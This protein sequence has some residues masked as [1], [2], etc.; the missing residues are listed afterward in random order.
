M[1]RLINT[2]KNNTISLIFT[3]VGI[4]LVFYALYRETNISYICLII[5]I[6]IAL[7]VFYDKVVE[8]L[9]KGPKLYIPVASLITIISIISIKMSSIEEY[10]KYSIWLFNGGSKIIRSLGFE[11]GTLLLVTLI[12]S[13]IFYYFTV[14]IIRIPVVLLL[15]YMVT[16]LFIKCVYRQENLLL[17]AFVLLFFCII[18][19]GNRESV[20]GEGRNKIKDKD[21]ISISWIFILIIFI[22]GVWI[23]KPNKLPKVKA[24]DYV[25]SY[26]LK[27]SSIGSNNGFSVESNKGRSINESTMKNPS[28]L[29][30]TF[31]G[32]NPKY[33][34]SHNYDY[35]ENENW[36]SGNEE[37]L[38]GINIK[39]YELN[40]L[41]DGT[42]LLVNK[43][44]LNNIKSLEEDNSL[45]KTL[46]LRINNYS[47][48]QIVH[49]INIMGANIEDSNENI[50][51]NE[52]GVLFLKDDGTFSIDDT[53]E[54]NYLSDRPSKGT[55]EE[56]IMRY[57]NKERY[58]GLLE[59]VGTIV[60]KKYGRAEINKI[61]SNY[62][63]TSELSDE[64]IELSKVIPEGN[65]SDYDIA[66]S[67]EDYL[68]KGNYKYNLSIPSKTSDED[69]I[70]HFIMRGKE[71]YCVQF[72]TAMTLMCRA[73]N[74][75]ARYVEGYSIDEEDKEDTGEY[76]VNES[77][78]HAFVEVYIA[79]FGWKIFDPTPALALDENSDL[80]TIINYKFIGMKEV[81]IFLS[82]IITI[83]FLIFCYK[84]TEKYRFYKNIKKEENEIAIEKIIRGSIKLLKKLD[85]EPYR[86]ETELNFAIRIE[87]EVNIN[88]GENIN[89][90]YNYKYGF[91]K[92]SKDEVYEALEVNKKIVELIKKRGSTKKKQG[93]L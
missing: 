2:L 19:L 56:A 3:I 75:P 14:K 17:Y 87:S 32:E 92:V 20:L 35:Y 5:I 58:L 26:F 91:K 74:I 81:I 40:A 72:A 68:S 61:Y 78:G 62:L 11:I 73:N 38:L 7:Y 57:F 33:L 22:I 44:N 69:Y 70:N 80:S 37:L 36:E 77:K 88:F 31:T 60:E 39:R 13:S 8:V 4:E 21:I 28:N 52:F 25:K 51:L 47:K 50:Y 53:Y 76:E 15:V 89:S 84:K 93:D 71:G 48:K 55:K 46:N 12:F 54:M 90:Y 67:I 43:S 41:V 23:P 34:I 24:L 83:A 49:P 79:G 10:I 59:E 29:L 16:I 27:N 45:Y 82:T 1:D 63:D 9:D 64:V 6:T 18:I 30:Y 42:K 65:I 66:K 85:Y 86:G